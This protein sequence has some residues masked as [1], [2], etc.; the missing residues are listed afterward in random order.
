MP[1]ARKYTGRMLTLEL[2]M[3]AFALLFLSPFYF[4]LA[5]SFKSMGEIYRNSASLPGVL[6]WENYAK[7]WEVLNFLQVSGNTLIVTLF[8]TVGISLI[9]AM[10]AY[11]IVRFPTRFNRFVFAMYIAAIVVPFQ[12]VMLPMVKLLGMLDI[13]N[14][15]PGLIFAYYGLGTAFATFLFSGFVKSLPYEIE[16]SAI[17]DGCSPYGVFWRIVFPLLRPMTATTLILNVMWLWNDF[18]LPLLLIHKPEL[19]TIQL[20]VYSL[21]GEFIK[22]WDVGLAALVMSMVP[23]IVFFLLLQRHVIEGISAGAVKG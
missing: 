3:V 1:S 22:R 17:V 4:V 9:T 5:N 23:I 8:G 21:F 19:R 7:A 14:T 18:L 11:R 6:R 15:I 2:A 10:A 12:A 20:A 16:E 13:I